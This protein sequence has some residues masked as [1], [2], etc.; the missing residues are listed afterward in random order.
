MRI[1]LNPAS[2]MRVH[3]Q[4]FQGRK[5]S[6]GRSELMPNPSWIWE[7]RFGG[8]WSGTRPRPPLCAAEGMTIATKQVVIAQIN[9]R[10]FDSPGFLISFST[11]V[12]HTAV[13]T[14]PGRASVH[15]A[16]KRVLE[17]KLD[18]PIIGGG[19]RNAAAARN[20][21]RGKA[22]TRQAEIGMVQQVEEF[23]PKLQLLALAELEVL[24]QH[25]V[26]VKQI[27][28]TQVSYARVAKHVRRLLARSQGRRDKGRRVKPAC[29]V[30]MAGVASHGCLYV[31]P[32]REIVGISHLIGAIVEAACVAEVAGHGAC[33]RLTG[34]RG[35]DAA[36]FPAA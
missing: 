4:R 24:L 10:P 14:G 25:E 26:H 17:S 34:L 27:R 35:N 30:L 3:H 1:H 31:L 12:T 16:L 28:A 21:N 36:D 5:G 19:V 32:E 9:V 29:Q 6:R 20:I 13:T 11:R 18:L 33:H 22:A 2:N 7:E 23:R 15:T 8:T